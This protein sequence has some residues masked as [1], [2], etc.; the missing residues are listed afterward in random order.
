MATHDQPGGG[1]TVVLCRRPARIVAGVAAYE[2][3]VGLHQQLTGAT[4]E[5][6]TM[7]ADW[8]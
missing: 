6:M 7:L 2:K 8:P 1:W 5:T 3:H 4:V